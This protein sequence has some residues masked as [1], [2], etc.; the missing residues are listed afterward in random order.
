MTAK[1][2]DG[3]E[4]WLRMQRSNKIAE[5][6]AR[7]L[8]Q[9]ILRRR[10]QPGEVLPSEAQM[11][12]RYGVGRASLREGLRILEA[13]G[14]IKIKSGPRGGPIVDAVGSQD[15]GRAT[16]F[17]FQVLGA[18]IGDLLE[19]RTVIE[20]V[21]ARMAAQRIT[22]E[23]AERLR[24]VLKAEEEEAS[25]A[26]ACAWGESTTEFHGLIASMTGN[27]VLDLYGRSLMDIH[28]ERIRP[29]FPPD[30]RTKVLRTHQRIA[31]AIIA[32]NAD[33]AQRLTSRH[34]EALTKSI[35]ELFP[36]LLDE[37]IDWL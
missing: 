29:I 12:V 33:E 2:G 15:F 14:L 34:I 37:V 27:H 28:G 4:E 23:S 35:K 36:G 26:T 11:L 3:N 9:E 7:D 19:A 16:S 24:A 10:M 30:Q 21:M 18:T 31:D 13:Y 17:Y 1:N 5:I 22:P 25:D 6:V 32:G 8:L 20:P